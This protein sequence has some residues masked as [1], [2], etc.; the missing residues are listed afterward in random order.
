MIGYG[1]LALFLLIYFLPS[2]LRYPKVF[3]FLAIAFLFYGIHTFIDATQE[4]PTTYSFIFEESAKLF[5]SAL[6]A[7]GTFVGL[8]GIIENQGV[9]LTHPE[10]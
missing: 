2:I 8:V 5:C 3:E 9:S 7:L 6:I 10:G 4:P 1:I